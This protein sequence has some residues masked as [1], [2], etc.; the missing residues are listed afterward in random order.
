MKEK[1]DF[2]CK[3][4]QLFYLFF[5]LFFFVKKGRIDTS[6]NQINDIENQVLRNRTANVYHLRQVGTF[7][8]VLLLF[9]FIIMVGRKYNFNILSLHEHEIT[10]R[11]EQAGKNCTLN[12][13]K[14]YSAV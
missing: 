11:K 5:Q 13:Q 14:V 8:I 3:L 2:I 4:R 6:S 1:Y 9:F 12:S 7:L 10:V